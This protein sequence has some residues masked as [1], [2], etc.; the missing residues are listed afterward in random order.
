[1]VRP[2][3][4]FTLDRNDLTKWSRNALVFL[5]PALLVLVAS[6]VKVVPTD[7]KYGAVVLYLLNLLVDLLRKFVAGAV[8]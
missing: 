2:S 5:A 3:E 6:I 4:R 7:F 8:K 1:M